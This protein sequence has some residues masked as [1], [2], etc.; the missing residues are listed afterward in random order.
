MYTA[1]E[2]AASLTLASAFICNASLAEYVVLES[3]SQ[4]LPPGHI[5]ADPEKLEVSSDLRVVLLSEGGQVLN[6]GSDSGQGEEAMRSQADVKLMLTNLV[7]NTRDQHASLGG[8]RGSSAGGIGSDAPV[9]SLDPY[10][11]GIQCLIE[12]VNAHVYRAD[13]RTDLEL[14]VTRTG[15]DDS[16]LLKWLKGEHEAEW[17]KEVPIVDGDRY[18]IKR[19]GYMESNVIQLESIPEV[20]I[21][22]KTTAV[23]WLAAKKCIPQAEK[24]LNMLEQ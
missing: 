5:V 19:E 22:Q 15:S 6:L 23:A 16:G 4:Q 10:I 18:V 8:T 9:W 11:T 12:T 24:L 17:P 3:N 2:L 7:S 14:K 21:D 13:K 1:K 20:T